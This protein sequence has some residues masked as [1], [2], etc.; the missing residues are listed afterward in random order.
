MIPLFLQ[1]VLTVE[2]FE[3]HENASPSDMQ[4]ILTINKTL[5]TPRV[6]ILASHQSG[7][8]RNT[9]IQE[10]T[11]TVSSY[12]E[13]MQDKKRWVVSSALGTGKS[14][15]LAA[16]PQSAKDGLVPFAEV[17][18]PVT[19]EGVPGYCE[20]GECS[21]S[22]PSPFQCLLCVFTSMDALTYPLIEEALRISRMKTV[23]TPFS[24]KMLL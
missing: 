19:A 4:H 24:F 3:L 11:I 16:S 5:T 22:C 13:T 1:N 20:Q 12:T 15:V 7:K 9:S 6:N 23:G 18:L 2:L 14:K 17:A 8:R 10:C 21:A